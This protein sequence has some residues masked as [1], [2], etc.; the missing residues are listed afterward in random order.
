MGEGDKKVSRV[1]TAEE[2]VEALLCEYG[3]GT[4]K[5]SSDMDVEEL[6]L[7]KDADKS[8]SKKNI[9]SVSTEE[10][11]NARSVLK[12]KSSMQEERIWCKRTLRRQ[13][14]GLISE[15]LNFQRRVA[16]GPEYLSQTC[17]T[18]SLS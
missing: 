15:T 14:V 6:T 11:K 2:I 12:M 8:N 17:C 9:D 5:A 7:E 18:I 3:E 10:V 13:A 4:K 16:L 1:K